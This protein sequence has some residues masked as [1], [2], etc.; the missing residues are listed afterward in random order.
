ML[1]KL[2]HLCNTSVHMLQALLGMVISKSLGKNT[3]WV[4]KV[5]QPQCLSVLGE[6]LWH[7]Q[8]LIASVRKTALCTSSSEVLKEKTE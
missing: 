7:K 4:R 8:G 5:L 6:V 1:L 2:L 3:F